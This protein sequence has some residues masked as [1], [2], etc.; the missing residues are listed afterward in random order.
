MDEIERSSSTCGLCK[1]PFAPGE[2]VLSQLVIDG[3]HWIRSDHNLNCPHSTGDDLLASWSWDVP[4]KKK[5]FALSETAIWQVIHKAMADGELRQQALTWIL[6]LMMA[7]KRKLRM[8]KT[9]RLKTNEFQTFQNISRKVELEVLIPH[10]TPANFKRLSHEL[11]AF[12]S[13][14]V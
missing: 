10:L 12:L 3:D 4:D 14:N 1:Q 9:R 2:T 11:D 6:C 5:R 13:E 8:I 7:R